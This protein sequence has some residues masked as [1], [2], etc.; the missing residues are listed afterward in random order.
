MELGRTLNPMTGILIKGGE[1]TE[2][3]E[4]DHTKLEAE[5]EEMQLQAPEH[6]RWARSFWQKLGRDKEGIFTT[7]FRERMALLNLD[8]ELQASRTMK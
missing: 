4:G 7:G 8:F 5:A 6:Y 1:D 3:H 2:K